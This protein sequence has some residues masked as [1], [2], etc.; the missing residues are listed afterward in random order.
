MIELLEGKIGSLKGVKIA[1][2]GLA[3]KPGTDDM[4]EAPS[5][6]I[7][8]NL[9]NKGAEI[10]A[11]DPEALKEAEQIFG[12]HG[13]LKFVDRPEDAVKFGKYV[14]IVTDWDE[15]KNEELYRGKVVID[16]RRIDE[17]KV[18]DDYE[19]VCW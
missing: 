14:L 1:V 7:I 16:G 6:K 9:L 5:V 13:R 15:Y 17:A 18:A 4:R 11:T 19:G 2:L 8:Q 3:F 12:T 10:C